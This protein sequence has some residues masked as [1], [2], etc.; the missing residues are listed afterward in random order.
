MH[1]APLPCS[2]SNGQEPEQAVRHVDESW[3][4]EMGS[5]VP[6]L[7]S[8]TAEVFDNIFWPLDHGSVIDERPPSPMEAALSSTLEQFDDGS[9][10]GE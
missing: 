6:R 7:S 8:P 4:S 2:P 9:V 5:I 10:V 1:A 3:G